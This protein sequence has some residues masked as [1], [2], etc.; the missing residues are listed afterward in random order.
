MFRGVDMFVDNQ[1]KGNMTRA[2]KAGEYKTQV[3]DQ[4]FPIRANH[5]AQIRGTLA[6]WQGVFPHEP[7]WVKNNFG[8]PSLFVRVDCVVRFEQVRYFEVE[9]RPNGMGLL[10]EFV[11]GF[12]EKRDEM[13]REWP[14]F[15]FVASPRRG[16]E[17][18]DGLW[19]E[20]VANQPNRL[21]LVRAEPQEKEFHAFQSRSVST[22]TTEGD[23]WYGWEMDWWEVVTEEFKKPLPFETGFALKPMQ[24]SKCRDVHFHAPLPKLTKQEKRFGRTGI[25]KLLAQSNSTI[26]QIEDAVKRNGQMFCQPFIMPML[27]GIPGHEL[28]IYRLMFGW[29]PS[30][31]T[32]QY[33][34]G[35]W[36]ARNSL[37]I[38]GAS[39]TLF[40]PV[41]LKD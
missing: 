32:W 6:K 14:D 19:L 30:Q 23:K 38:H 2:V 13:R 41:V 31:N 3:T 16:K 17:T 10:A 9:D 1:K 5:I 36:N 21:A 26:D 33:I 37:R 11:P 29:S 15:G 28:M 35:C 24:G 7:S 8:V 27:S 34:G 39:D 12:K 22:V 25:E 18:E 40:G 4:E 20:N